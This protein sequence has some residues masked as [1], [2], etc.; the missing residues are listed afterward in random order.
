MKSL[1]VRRDYVPGKCPLCSSRDSIVLLESRDWYSSLTESSFHVRLCGACSVVFTDFPFEEG[2]SQTFYH[3][4][5]SE[6]L[7]D[8]Y[9]R[10]LNTAQVTRVSARFTRSL[11]YERWVCPAI[12]DYD[13]LNG[14][15]KSALEVGCGTGMTL[16]HLREK[17]WTVRGVEPNDTLGRRARELGLE[18]TS[19]I[20]ERMTSTLGG[21]DLV[22]LIHSLEHTTDPLTALT[23]CNDVMKTGGLLVIAVPNFDSPARRFFGESWV[24]LDVPRHLFHFT[25]GSVRLLLTKTG[26]NVVEVRFDNNLGQLF[27]SVGRLIRVKW[28][29]GKRGA[30]TL[31]PS[32][33]TYIKSPA[34]ASLVAILTIVANLTYGAIF[35]SLNLGP[36]NSML[37]IASKS[38]GSGGL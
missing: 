14:Q 19:E 16:L 13:N 21:F 22:I 33:L 25:P 17:G 5:Y 26:F 8:H 7:T 10:F 34:R 3:E 23:R 29:R 32:L 2:D 24:Q 38:H 27:A 11:G 20:A 9:P 35:S 6:R 12:A 37:V 31:V 30:Q 28:L 15:G 36:R 1:T 18:V 4:G